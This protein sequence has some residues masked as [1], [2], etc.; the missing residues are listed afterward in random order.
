MEYTHAESDEN[1]N[2]NTNQCVHRVEFVQQLLKEAIKLNFT[3]YITSP[4]MA[5]IGKNFR[6]LTLMS[7]TY[8]RGLFMY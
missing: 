8:G 5:H 3:S 2:T 6:L 4:S 1:N 7:D